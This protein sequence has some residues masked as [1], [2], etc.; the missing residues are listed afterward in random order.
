[1]KLINNKKGFTL[2]E[3][4]AVI[5]VLSLIL[6]LI[7][8]A[9]LDNMNNSRRRTVLIYAQRLVSNAATVYQNY[10]AFNDSSDLGGLKAGASGDNT[11]CI[12]IDKLGLQNMGTY[13]GYIIIT[14]GSSA[15]GGSVDTGTTYKVY[16]TDGTYGING[17]DVSGNPSLSTTV[18]QIATIAS[19]TNHTG[20]YTAAS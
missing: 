4:L 12:N 19:E 7:V 5:I 3:L 14:P 13:K 9:V 10:K 17:V 20:C 11:Y 8:P 6:V 2:V 18:T 16:I 1:M 15:A